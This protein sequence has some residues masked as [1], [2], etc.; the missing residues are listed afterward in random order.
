[1]RPDKQVVELVVGHNLPEA[2]LG[3]QLKYGE[4][5]S[6]IIAQT[7]ETMMIEDYAAWSGRA[8]LAKVVWRCGRQPN[9][10]VH[11]KMAFILFPSLRYRQLS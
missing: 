4:G 7:G 5:L 11:S 8:A 1:M 10:G 9:I 3:T 6:G 2:Y